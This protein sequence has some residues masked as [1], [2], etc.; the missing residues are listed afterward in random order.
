MQITRLRIKNYRAIQQLDTTRCGVS[1]PV[2]KT[3]KAADCPHIRQAA[4][5][6]GHLLT[7]PAETRAALYLAIVEA[8]ESFVGAKKKPGKTKAHKWPP[9]P[10]GHW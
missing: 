2:C 6:L 4:E 10:R 8:G 3:C 5:I 7:E 9:T 1:G